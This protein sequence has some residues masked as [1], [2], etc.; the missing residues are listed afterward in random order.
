MPRAGLHRALVVEQAAV[1]A[2]EMGYDRLTLAAVAE[3]FEVRQ[4]SLYKHVDGLDG[5][6]RDLAVLGLREMHAALAGAT[7]GKARGDALRSLASA[8]REW[9][10]AHPGRYS[11]T[12]RAPD[13]GPADAEQRGASDDILGIVLAV[14]AGYGLEGEDAVDAARCLRSA[15]HGVVSLE[16]AGGFGIP[17]SRDTS[18]QVLTDILDDAFATGSWRTRRH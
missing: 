6:R 1:L 16:A 3:H 9:A 2:D 18:Y 13:T 11:A 5:L 14:L 17:R 7:V 12:V 15:L 4:P 10:R 8:F